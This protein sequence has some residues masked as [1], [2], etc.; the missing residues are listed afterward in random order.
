MGVLEPPNESEKPMLDI[1][2]IISV[3]FIAV[4]GTSHFR[5]CAAETTL[6]EYAQLV[7][8]AFV[9]G[10]PVELLQQ[11]RDVVITRAE[12]IRQAA[13]LRTDWSRLS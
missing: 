7:G 6:R 12:K 8:D 9:H 3:I 5:C 11:R 13:A 1:I 4:Q 10:Q 2:I